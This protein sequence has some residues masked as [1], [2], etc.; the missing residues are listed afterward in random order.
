MVE[1]SKNFLIYNGK[2]K[3]WG[4]LKELNIK[5]LNLLTVILN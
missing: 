3:N 4:S 1:N 2:I 5:E